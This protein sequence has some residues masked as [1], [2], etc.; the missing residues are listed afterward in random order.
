MIHPTKG[1]SRIIEKA[2]SETSL[3][4]WRQRFYIPAASYEVVQTLEN[5]KVAKGITLSYNNTD[6]PL[7]YMNMLSKDTKLYENIS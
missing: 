7:V 3:I 1:S 5:I 6:V 4:N 2:L